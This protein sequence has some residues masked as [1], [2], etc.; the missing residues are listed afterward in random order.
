MNSTVK[1]IEF[2]R[3][4]TSTSLCICQVELHLATCASV[5]RQEKGVPALFYV[6]E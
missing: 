1:P 3:E 5:Y 4:K 6:T 2:N